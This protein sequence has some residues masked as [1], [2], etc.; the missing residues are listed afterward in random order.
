MRAEPRHVCYSDLAGIE[1]VLQDVRELI[2]R[3][4]KHPEVIAHLRTAAPA[5]A[6]NPVASD[7]MPNPGYLPSIPL[8]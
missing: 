8:G 4:L 6:Q 3:P 1:G 5:Q 7:C 2:E